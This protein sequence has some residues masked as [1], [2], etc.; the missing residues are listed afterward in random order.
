MRIIQLSD[1]HVKANR[2]FAFN[3]ADSAT[4][5]EKTV[6]HLS[7][8]QPMPDCVVIS[9]DL[10]EHGEAGAYEL[11]T[12][13]LAGLDAPVYVLP[14][15]HDNRENLLRIL[16]AYCPTD[17]EAAPHI[18]YAVPCGHVRLVIIDSSRPDAHSGRLHAPVARWLE[19]TLAEN[20]NT[21]ALVF[22]HHPP[23]L[24]GMGLMDEPYDRSEE[25][26]RILRGSPGARYCC[27]HLHRGL[28]TVWE[29]IPAV[30]CPPVVM[31]IKLD[32]SPQGGDVFSLGAPGYLLHHVYGG[33]I[34]THFCRVPGAFPHGGPYSFSNPPRLGVK[35]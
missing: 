24:S 23:F 15:N 32:L 11:V 6:A 17:P 13:M 14:G 22:A 35:A 33:S 31:H 2:A 9:G 7:A 12:E 16:G 20:R 3:A 21:P 18:C 4:A 28:A 29:G 34:N 27:G 19:K 25:L 1:L 10:A 26:A 5:L 30:V 8:M